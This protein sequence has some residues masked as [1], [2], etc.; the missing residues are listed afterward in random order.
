MRGMFARKARLAGVGSV[1]LI[2]CAV[3]ALLV[4]L[5]LRLANGSEHAAPAAGGFAP[6]G[7]HALPLALSHLPATARGPVSESLGTGGGGYLVSHATRALHAANPAQHLQASFGSHGVLV[8]S[9]GTR[10]GLGLGAIGY[11]STLT[12]LTAAK[13]SARLNRV[14][15]RH[16]SAEEWYVNGPAGLEQGFDIPRAPRGSSRTPLTLR[17]ALS[18]N[19]RPAL[20]ADGETVTFSSPGGPSLRYSGMVATD[21]SGRSL[22]SWLELRPQE[23]LLR[24]NAANAR[25]PLRIDPFMQSGEKLTGADESGSGEFAAAV[26]L[27]S[28]GKLLAVGGPGDDGGAGAVWVFSRTGTTWSQS[29][30][31]LT[32]KSGEEVG[33]GHFGQSVA[34]SSSGKT[35]F[36]G[37]PGDNGGVGAAWVFAGKSTLTQEGAKLTAKA[38]EEAGEGHFGQS[39]ALS[40]PGK[41]AIVGAP[42]AGGDVG[43][44]WAFVAGTKK[45]PGWAQEGKKIAPKAGEETGSGE[46]GAGVA[47]ESSSGE[48]GLIGAPA[49]N[50]E[51]GAAFVVGPSGSNWVQQ[52]TKLLGDEES[53]KGRFGESVAI[54]SKAKTALVGGPGDELKDGAAWAFA[55]SEGTWLQQGAKLTPK[56][57]EEVGGGGFGDSVALSSEGETALVGA[58]EDN[59]GAGAAW[60]FRRPESSWEQLGGKLTGSGESG[61]ARLGTAV[62]LEAAGAKAIVG[63]PQDASGTGAAWYFTSPPPEAPAN[64]APPKVSGG[65]QQGDTLEVTHG[66]WSNSPSGYSE[67]WL[68]CNASGGECEAIEEATDGSYL[69]EAPDVGHTLRVEE[70]AYN[71]GGESEPAESEK[72]AVIATLPLAAIAGEDLSGCVG[73]PLTLD[74]SASTPASEISSYEWEFGDSSSEAGATV[75]HSYASP[76]TYTATLTITRGAE[77]RSDSIEVAITKCMVGAAGEVTVH[78][79]EGE[80]HPVSDADISYQS[81]AG[82]RAQTMTESSGEA[83]ISGLSPGTATLYAYKSGYNPTTG[84]VTV[85]AAGEGETTITLEAGQVVGVSATSHQMTEAQIEAAGINPDAPGNSVVYQFT[86]RLGFGGSTATLS[87][88]LNAAG[89]FIPPC[90]GNGGTGGGAGW[91]C[92]STGCSTGAGDGSGDFGDGSGVGGGVGDGEIE[93]QPIEPPGGGGGS[94]PPGSPPVPAVQWLILH[95]NVSMLKQFLEVSMGVINLSPEEPFELTHNKATLNL[96]AGLSLAPTPSPQSL[97]QTLGNIK[98]LESA[99]VNWIVRGDEPGEYSL[100]A[101]Y[102]GT[103]EPFEA[104]LQAL[105]TVP[106]PFKVWGAEALKLKVQADS[107]KYIRATPYHVLLG[108]ED[109]ADI[110]LYNVDL[111]IDEDFHENFI[112]QPRQQ[113]SE[114]LGELKPKEPPVYIKRPYILVPEETS[115]GNF[116][117]GIS[118]AT[119]AGQTVHPGEGIQEVTP[120]PLYELSPSPTNQENG[121]L[122]LTWKKKEGASGYGTAEGFQVYDTPNLQTPFETKP[123]EVRATPTSPLV[124]QLPASATEAYVPGEP[125]KPLY[126]AVST[127]EEGGHFKL[128][129]PLVEAVTQS[130]PE[131]GRCLTVEAGK[132]QYSSSKCT[133][134]GGKKVDE[135][136]PGAVKGGVTFSGGSVK[137]ETPAKT[138][139]SCKSTAGK[140]DAVADGLRAVSLTFTGC[141][142]GPS[143][144]TSAGAT[145]G[146]IRTNSLTGL[147]VW[148]K[149]AKKAALDLSPAGDT[150]VL[151]FSCAGKSAEVDGSVLVAVKTGKASTATALKFKESKG[152]QK[153]SEYETAEATKVK[154]TLEAHFSA[155]PTEAIGLSGTVTLTS[156]EALEINPTI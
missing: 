59:L 10:V 9:G 37:A 75:Q 92:T 41:T 95:G 67:Q 66:S 137:F 83:T 72:T 35:L 20:S 136:S 47:L 97:T 89:Q 153:P 129:M 149:K 107:G 12:P 122:R 125:G 58:D 147:L 105:A 146:E 77:H 45:S 115:L 130:P 11:G 4:G 138:V 74:G 133:K 113:F 82:T 131:F 84:H 119:F 142:T 148:E 79:V 93:F 44:A 141:E 85:N 87:C 76:G 144:C 86:A 106:N 143:T 40:G 116:N 154:D 100:S 128:E 27:S 139:V 150:A 36:V 16:R 108:V 101:G 123:V 90:S 23:L 56:S 18:G 19:A 109:A 91:S 103:L 51:V 126:Y 39:V 30:E 104:E 78:V 65:T 132:G 29:G 28:N 114:E 55:N 22:P 1:A 31:K 48:V 61:A 57:G 110:P 70:T 155:G 13:P 6:A 118:S 50:G 2:V 5:G 135:W 8:S 42:A 46:F 63:G 69:L 49:N 111:A 34:L 98:P 43:A 117:P 3:L 68:R 112:F 102:Q 151:A 127:V 88:Y 124:E 52:G 81:G 32:P 53:G 96:P 25:Y 24:V 121:L 54:S 134:L 7:S 64:S 60:A 15:Y 80:G 94:P 140:G 99:S 14:T 71:A 26:E 145:A 17:L 33:A 62:A 120:P 156:E 152:T 21:A 38:G 73:E